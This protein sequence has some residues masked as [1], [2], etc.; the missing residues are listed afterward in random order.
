MTYRTRVVASRLSA[1]LI[2]SLF[3]AALLAKA[4]AAESAHF[5]SLTAAP[6]DKCKSIEVSATVDPAGKQEQ[7]QL[8]LH[9]SYK[10]APGKQVVASG[11]TAESRAVSTDVKLNLANGVGFKTLKVEVEGRLDGKKSAQKKLT[12]T[13]ATVEGE[14]KEDK[15]IA[16]SSAAGERESEE[17]EETRELTK[18]REQP[19]PQEGIAPSIESPAFGVNYISKDYYSAWATIDPNGAPTNVKF[20]LD[21][22]H[23]C[24]KKNE[25]RET[26]VYHHEV[27]R[28]GPRAMGEGNWE[29]PTSKAGLMY[30]ES[31]VGGC[32]TVDWWLVA[33]NKFG[34]T[35]TTPEVLETQPTKHGSCSGKT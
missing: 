15:E 27:I 17:Q 18:L 8:L 33:L 12:L 3:F 1:P 22:V 5:E 20:I 28:E 26:G 21:W 19:E 25:C 32:Q 2:I 11:E 23:K 35:K 29:T 7:Y 4:A 14:D 13:C 6:L 30:A 10:G 9:A 34:A 16:E 24:N 31:P